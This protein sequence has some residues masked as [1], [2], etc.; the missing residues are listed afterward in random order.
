MKRIIFLAI[1]FICAALIS[2]PHDARGSELVGFARRNCLGKPYSVSER[3]GPDS[4]DCSGLL[5]YVCNSLN[6][7]MSNGNT[8]SQMSYGT[9]VGIDALKDRCAGLEVGDIL[10]FDYEADGVSDHTAIYAGDEKIIHAVSRGVSEDTLSG[11]TGLSGGQEYYDAVCSVRR[12][13]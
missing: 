13:K 8:D 6:I 11:R 12:L 3:L 9:E 5:W 4:F 10:F 7:E 2:K 1:I